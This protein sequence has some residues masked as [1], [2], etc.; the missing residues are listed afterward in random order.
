MENDLKY[1]FNPASVAVVGVSRDPRKLGSVILSNL[2]DAKFKGEIYPINPKYDELFGYKVYP[3]VSAIPEDVDMVCIAIPAPF[4]KG[5]LEDSAKKNAKSAIIITAGFKETGE[6]GAKLEKEIIETAKAHGIRLLGP[7][8]LGLMTPAAKLNASFAASNPTEGNI[9]FLSQS[10]AFCTA[11]LDMSLEK[12]V[13]FSHFISL[14]N[15]SDLNENDIVKYWLEDDEVKVMGAYLEEIYDGQNLLNIVE[16]S[17]TKKPLIIFKPGKTQEAKNA[18]SSHTGSMAGSIQ[19]FQTAIK[20]AGI[21][22][23]NEINH[24]FNLM[25]AFSWSHIPKGPRVAVITN[26]GGP[27][28]IA[29]DEIIGHGMKMAEI[30]D[31]TKK[32]IRKYLPPTASVNNPIDVIGDAL[33]ERYK[34]PIDVLAEDDNVDAILVILTPQLVTQIE[35]TAKLIINSAK[36]SKKPILSVFLGGKYVTNGLQRLHDNRIPSFRYINDAI[37]VLASMYKYGQVL[38]LYEKN[39][40]R[41]ELLKD[42]GK[43]KYHEELSKYKGDG[44][45]AIPEELA[46][47]LAVEI[48]LDMP[49]Q[50][51]AKSAAEAIEFSK[52]KYPVVIK[53]TTDVIAHKTDEKA[54]YLNISDPD[55][56]RIFYEKLESLLKDNFNVEKPE[57]LVQEQIVAEEE[58]FIGANRDGAADVYEDETSGFGHLLAFGKGG[59][60]TEI[61]KDIAY[62]L[63]PATEYDITEALNETKTSQIL[64]GAR[65]KE[66]L[67]KEKVLTAIK[68]IQRLVILYPE[69]LS[70]DINPLLVTKDRAVSVDMKVFIG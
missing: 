63:V 67:A 66:P 52:D 5:I 21:L 30:T 47:K 43:G 34:A 57:I 22:E 17:E 61:Y 4:V 68:A 28:I 53:A 59:I 3:S 70:I 32:E 64:Q 45:V 24:M 8:C 42:L 58:V 29:T 51:M 16:K 39:Q 23:A 31:E 69:I 48:G 12:N 14:G 44:S 41:N 25:M 65:G 46:Q 37:E 13:G 18:I 20:Q 50:I 15:K 54:L 7:N 6:E 56:L 2:I 60:Y 36:L 40:K 11:I 27:G 10:G 55:Q 62:A 9:A 33:A 49:K 38:E 26:A 19:T 1:L 35:D